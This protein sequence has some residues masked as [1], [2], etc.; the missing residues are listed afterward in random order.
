MKAQTQFNETFNE[1]CRIVG[2]I[3]PWSNEWKSAVKKAGF[4]FY[5]QWINSSNE[6]AFFA[7]NHAR[8]IQGAVELYANEKKCDMPFAK[9]YY[10]LD[11]DVCS[12]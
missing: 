1:V 7:T 9:E 10:H 12:L 2:D 3:R 8:A 4:K 5:Y 6:W 11:I